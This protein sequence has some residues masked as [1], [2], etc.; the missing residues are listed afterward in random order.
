MDAP[1]PAKDEG[2]I[3]FQDVESAA[4]A[5]P[6]FARERE[7]GYPLQ[8]QYTDM[9]ITSINSRMSRAERA[10]SAKVAVEYQAL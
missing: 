3:Q 5:G 1:A 6:R 7:H 4:A 10:V 2:R 8:R 9:S